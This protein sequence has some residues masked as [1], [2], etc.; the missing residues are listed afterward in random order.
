MEEAQ[1]KTHPN[2]NSDTPHE[3]IGNIYIT[4]YKPLLYNSNDITVVMI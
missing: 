2:K 1:K 3:K 4:I